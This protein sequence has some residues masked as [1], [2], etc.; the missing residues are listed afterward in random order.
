MKH[1]HHSN[2]GII[3]V[4]WHLG[5]LFVSQKSNGS[6]RSN[7]RKSLGLSEVN[8]DD[9]SVRKRALPIGEELK[10]SR[11]SANKVGSVSRDSVG[12]SDRSNSYKTDMYC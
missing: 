12:T 11:K 9:E 2:H 7:G 8:M 4:G 5:S 1:R 6:S 3:D 10:S